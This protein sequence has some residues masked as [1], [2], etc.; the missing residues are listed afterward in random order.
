MIVVM[1]GSCPGGR[2]RVEGVRRAY[3]V[4]DED[5]S[6]GPRMM[7]PAVIV[8]L[9]VIVVGF[10]FAARAWS[11]GYYRAMAAGQYVG[12]AFFVSLYAP[13]TPDTLTTLATPRCSR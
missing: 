1:P 10:Y 12:G 13:T 8:A 5:N 2:G 6:F 9:V 4:G 3:A 11:S 7:W